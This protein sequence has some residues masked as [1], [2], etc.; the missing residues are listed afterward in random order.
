LNEQEH[1]KFLREVDERVLPKREGE[2]DDQYAQRM[3]DYLNN[4]D[5]YAEKYK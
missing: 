5:I 2:T 4:H 1:R 3:Y